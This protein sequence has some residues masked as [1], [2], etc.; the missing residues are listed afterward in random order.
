MSSKRRLQS[1]SSCNSAK[2]VGLVTEK[3]KPML[4][5]RPE[6]CGRIMQPFKLNDDASRNNEVNQTRGTSNH[7]KARRG[8]D[9]SRGGALVSIRRRS[10][11]NGQRVGPGKL[12]I[13]HKLQTLTNSKLTGRQGMRV[14]DIC[15]LYSLRG[16]HY[17]KSILPLLML[18][19]GRAV[20]I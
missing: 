8:L 9:G 3:T 2:N 18:P 10:R 19:R 15:P 5:A 16:Y 11:S 4:A 7:W 13:G 20:V 14:D 6:S 1:H 12:R 17:L